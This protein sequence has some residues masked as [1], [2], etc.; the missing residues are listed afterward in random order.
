MSKRAYWALLLAIASSSLERSVAF[1]T[2][3]IT[4]PL[5]GFVSS[6]RSSRDISWINHGGRIGSATKRLVVESRAQPRRLS[7]RTPMMMSTVED[8]SLSPSE[9]GVSP[10]LDKFR[11]FGRESDSEMQQAL[12]FLV[13]VLPQNQHAAM[14]N[15][16]QRMICLCIARLCLAQWHQPDQAQLFFAQAENGTESS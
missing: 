10:S 4:K 7:L 16:A 9:G 13:V 8:R 2:Y 11:F 12:F 15:S 5:P 3:G 14:C 6:L 1:S